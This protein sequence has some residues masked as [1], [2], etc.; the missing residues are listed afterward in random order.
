MLG[1]ADSGDTIHPVVGFA[2]WGNH[3]IRVHWGRA[4]GGCRTFGFL[5]VAGFSAL[6]AFGFCT[7]DHIISQQS[8]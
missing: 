3:E 6:G 5:S 8:Q 7:H 1:S 2:V 4:A